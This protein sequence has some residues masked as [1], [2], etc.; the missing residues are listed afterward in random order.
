MA[1][2]FAHETRLRHEQ[3]ACVIDIGGGTSDFSVIRL[4][5]Q[6]RNSQNR[7]KDILANAGIRIGGNDFDRD[8]SVRGFMPGLGYG[9]MLKPN[10]Y[11]GRILPVPFSPYVTL[12]EWSSINSLYAYKEKE[13]VRK[14]YEESAEPDKVGV[15]YENYKKRIGTHIS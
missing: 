7:K 9:T 4:S 13:A 12:S 10:P 1:A 8:L 6:K 14:L 2:A 11:N 5:P 3:L 15:L